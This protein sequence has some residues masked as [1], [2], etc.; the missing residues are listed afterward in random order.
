MCNCNE[1]HKC[2][3]TISAV[4]SGSVITLPD[5]ARIRDGH[6]RSISVRRANG[7]VLLNNLGQQLASDGVIY[8][9][10]LNLV[11]GSGSPLAQMPVQNLWRDT[12][13]PEPLATNNWKNIDPTQ[14]TITLSTGASGYN[15]AHVIELVFELNEC[16]NC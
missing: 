7:Q 13:Y 1:R 15:A 9:A 3:L 16:P 12:N 14:S 5:N 11:D 10:H 4:T 8:T 2:F 6:V